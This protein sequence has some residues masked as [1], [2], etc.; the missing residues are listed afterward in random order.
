MRAAAHTQT[1]GRWARTHAGTRAR[2]HARSCQAHRSAGA[3]LPSLNYHPVA[4][5]HARAHLVHPELRALWP[6]RR[7]VAPEACAQKR[8]G[9]VLPAGA[10]TATGV[11]PAGLSAPTAAGEG[12]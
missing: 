7:Q 12:S 9:V 11:A 4:G 10:S 6:G 8:A 2:R 1:T 5:G 3:A